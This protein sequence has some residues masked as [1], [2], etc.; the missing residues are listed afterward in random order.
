RE[1][2]RHRHLHQPGFPIRGNSFRFPAAAAVGS[3]WDRGVMRRPFL[4]RAECRTPALRRRISLSLANLS[5]RGRLYGRLCFRYRRFRRSDRARGHGVRKIFPRCFQLRLPGTA[6]LRRCLVDRTRS[7][8]RLEVR[9]R[10]S[11]PFHAGEIAFDRCSHRRWAFCRPQATNRVSASA[12]RC[13]VDLW[14]AVRGRAVGAVI[15]LGLIAS[16]SSMTWIGPRVTMSMGED[17]WLLRLLGRKNSQGIPTYA[18]VLQLLFV[19]LL[20]LTRSFE[21][22]VVYIQF[23]LLLC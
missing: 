20:L 3:W 18:I 2:H 4:R 6:L 23:S 9:Q 16:I 17:H 15:C 10:L 8:Q 11:K 1:H 12:R 7:S 21:L 13:D 22:V 5:P 14:R 19:N